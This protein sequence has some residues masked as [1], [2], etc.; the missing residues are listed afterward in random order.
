ML[1]T[2]AWLVGAIAA[3]GLAVTV[4]GWLLPVEHV[5]EARMSCSA[6]PDRVFDLVSQVEK[7]PTWWSEISRVEMLEPISGRIRFRQHTGAGPIVMEVMESVPPSR[8][9][10]RIADPDQPFGGTWTWEIESGIPGPL[11]AGTHLKLTERGEVYNPLFRFMS[12]YVFGYEGT[13]QS[14]IRA[15]MAA[16]EAGG[17]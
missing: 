7:Y 14:H 5:A 8:F 13:M 16:A 15:L 9:V 12:R 10:T 4:V 2:L 6:S 3:L 11:P 1:R 17:T